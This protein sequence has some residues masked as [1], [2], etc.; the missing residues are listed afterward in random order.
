MN[1]QNYPSN[2]D[3][4]STLEVNLS[5]IRNNVRVM[6]NFAQ[7][8]VKKLAVIKANGY[9]LGAVE[10]AKAL[11]EIDF[12]AVATIGEALELRKAGIQQEIMVFS[13]V[14][15]HTAPYFVGYNIIAVISSLDQLVHLESGTRVHVQFDT[16]MYRFGILPSEAEKAAQILQ[17][18]P[19]QLEGILTHFAN[20]GEPNHISVSEQMATFNTI[21][22]L[23]PNHL[24]AHTANS[25]AIAFYPETHLDM[26]RIGVS[27][28][29]YA[30][31]STPIHGLQEVA[32]WKSTIIH[33]KPVKKGK[34]I[35][36]SWTFIAPEDGYVSIVP[37][38]YADGLKRELGNQIVF[39]VHEAYLPVAGRI[40]MDYSTVFSTYPLQI[41]T[42]VE[43]LG[44]GN[45]SA[46]KMAEATRTI[47]YEILTSIGLKRVKR[48]YHY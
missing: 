39:K 24:I 19:I 43:V 29:G 6:S 14:Q 36:Y 16:G 4:T 23:F 42:E 46:Y 18:A 8:S 10:I 2:L 12:F 9:G 44:A 21:R 3:Y 35:G 20:S 25:G 45:H 27:L 48:V 5:A 40:T 26:I 34:G 22:A 11:P 47:P 33:S 7:R 41:G 17:K 37:V 1:P 13:P 30:P 15:A 28:Y 38:G 31:S 32:V